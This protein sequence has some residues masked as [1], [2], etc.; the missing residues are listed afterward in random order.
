MPKP[1]YGAR[2]Q[3]ERR[4]VKQTVDSGRAI[5]SLCDQ[6]I[7]PGEAWDLDHQ[8]GTT[9]YRGPAHADCNRSDGARRGNQMRRD[10]QPRWVF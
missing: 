1:Q 4:K 7:H 6:P 8:P 5:C 9:L 2:H 10:S 3:A